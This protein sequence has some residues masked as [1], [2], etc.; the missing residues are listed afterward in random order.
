MNDQQDGDQAHHAAWNPDDDAADM[1]VGDRRYPVEAAEAVV[2]RVQHI[3]FQGGIA[4]EDDVGE[5]RQPQHHYSYA[6]A[7]AL[8]RRAAVAHQQ[9]E[10]QAAAPSMEEHSAELM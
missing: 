1:L 3:M 7:Q 5:N 2:G 9:P 4:A 10:E 6:M 8:R